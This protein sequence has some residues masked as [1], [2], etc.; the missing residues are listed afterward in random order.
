MTSLLALA[1]LAGTFAVGLAAVACVQ[2]AHLSAPGAAALAAGAAYPIGA[3]IVATWMRA[4]AAAGVSWSLPLV[5]VP[6]IAGIAALA[7]MGRRGTLRSVPARIGSFLDSPHAGS[8]RI[9]ALVLLAWLALRF[10]FLQFEALARPPLP[11]EAWLDTASRGTVW[12]ASRG[13]VPFVPAAEWIGERYLASQ[14][15]G[16]SLLPLLDAQLAFV[17]GNFDD[18]VIHSPWPMFWL[19]QALLV[20]GSM[21]SVGASAVAALAAAAMVGTLPLS[22]AHA[23]LGGTSALPLGTYLLLAAVFATR[24]AT[25]RAL[26]DFAVVAAAVVGVVWS[27]R[28]GV[29]WVPVL[30]PIAAA[31]MRPAQA[32]RIVAGLVAIAAI[33][34]SAL[35]RLDPFAHGLAPGA[36]TPG[37]ATVA[38]HALLHGN[39]HLLAYAAVALAALAWR[40]WRAPSLVG[41]TGSVGIGVAVIAVFATTSAGRAT[42]GVPGIVGQA[43]TAF[44]PLLALWVARVA[45]SWV[46]NSEAVSAKAEPSPR[47][48]AGEASD[49]VEPVP[50]PGGVPPSS[51][52]T[53]A[54]R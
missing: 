39:W 48:A 23:A 28:A 26:A 5:V 12:Y 13:I 3:L 40:E 25:T 34:A 2:R 41:L 18:T 30:L 7:W 27:S 46:R 8:A 49:A 37:M 24:T 15:P 50:R 17:I 22:N 33:A 16:H 11:W 20:I 31:A 6:T 9:V 36:P 35:A 32:P 45:W 51:S 19:S 47:S 53:V 4:L 21:R 54:A 42:I 44:A 38:E 43:M 29:L 52:S 14:P 10:A 1:N